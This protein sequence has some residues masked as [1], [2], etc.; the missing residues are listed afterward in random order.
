MLDIVLGIVPLRLA[1]LK[2]HGPPRQYR[3]KENCGPQAKTTR[4][5]DVL[6]R[7]MDTQTN[8]SHKRLFLG[9]HDRQ[10][11]QIESREWTHLATKIQPL[12]PRLKSSM[13]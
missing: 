10:H 3:S 8:Q 11:I 9:I 4:L 7:E 12:Q 2:N 13:S 1:H 6:I 5:S